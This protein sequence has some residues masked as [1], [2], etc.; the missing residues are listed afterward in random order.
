VQ[1]RTG[2]N[3]FL[4]LQSARP[5]EGWTGGAVRSPILAPLVSRLYYGDFTYGSERRVGTPAIQVRSSARTASIHLDVHPQRREHFRV[6]V[7]AIQ[8]FLFHFHLYTSRERK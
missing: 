7:C 3:D 1:F 2:A 4:I 6:D 8:K 5:F